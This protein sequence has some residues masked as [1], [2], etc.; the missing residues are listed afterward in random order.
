M[1]DWKGIVGTGFARDEFANYIASIHLGA[2]RPQFVV[3]HNTAVP[4]LA[5]WHK[6]SGEQRMKNL[7]S[8]YRDTQ[9]WSAGPHLFVADDRILGIHA[10]DDPGRAFAVV[11]RDLVG[12]GTGGR[13]RDGEIHGAAEGQRDPC[14]GTTASARRPRPKNSAIAQ[15]R[16]EYH[17]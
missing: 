12:R 10:A 6:V 5:D 11:E 16:P 17:A 3:L 9:R 14:V 1:P 2:W 13:L 15:R 7:E 8:Y 4:K